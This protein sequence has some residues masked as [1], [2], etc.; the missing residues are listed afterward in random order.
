MTNKPIGVC[1][2]HDRTRVSIIVQSWFFTRFLLLHTQTQSVQKKKKTTNCIR[3]L[4][5]YDNIIFYLRR[6][7]NE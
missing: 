1:T 5:V 3:G 4:T 6:N 7:I 2:A